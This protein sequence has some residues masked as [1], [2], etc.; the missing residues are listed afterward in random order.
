M[1]VRG[2]LGRGSSF[3]LESLAGVLEHSGLAEVE[4]LAVVRHVTL[5]ADMEALLLRGRLGGRGRPRHTPA[6]ATLFLWP[7]L[8]CYTSYGGT[9]Y[10]HA[11]AGRMSSCVLTLFEVSTVI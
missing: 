5:R 8:R 3:H 11:C 7:H 2:R 9:Y 1:R 6:Q 4:Q 10:G